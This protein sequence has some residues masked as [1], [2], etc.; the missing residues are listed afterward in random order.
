MQYVCTILLVLYILFAYLYINTWTI[1]KSSKISFTIIFAQS[2]HKIIMDL[3]QTI[4]CSV[5]AV[6]SDWR[7]SSF[8]YIWPGCK[9]KPQELFKPKVTLEGVFSL[10]NTSLSASLNIV[11]IISF[12]TSRVAILSPVFNPRDIQRL[13]M[14][15]H[16]LWGTKNGL[17][18]VEIARDIQSPSM[19]Y[20]YMSKWSK[21]TLSLPMTALCF[22]LFNI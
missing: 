13:H 8:M 5:S 1:Y 2:I 20:F 9:F 6:V 11:F 4:S 15:V 7:R 10:N 18:A 19:G 12:I 21:T 22:M 16:L 3:N 14:S 17:I